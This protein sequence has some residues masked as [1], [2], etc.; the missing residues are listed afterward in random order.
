MRDVKCEISSI[1]RDEE[2]ASRRYLVTGWMRWWYKG[3]ASGAADDCI[4]G[5]KE[6]DSGR[7]GRMRMGSRASI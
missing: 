7:G 3:D 5:G 4:G 1:M 2:A 6:R